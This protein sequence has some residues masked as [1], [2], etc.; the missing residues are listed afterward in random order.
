M[1]EKVAIEPDDHAAK[2]V[3]WTAAGQQFFL[4]TPFQPAVEGSRGGEYLA[5]YLFDADGR[6]SEHRIVDLGARE[7][8]D[9]A[10]A[11]AQ[12]QAMFE[13]L[14]PVEYRRIAVFPFAVDHDGVEFGLVLREPED[15]EDDAAVE[16]QPGNYMAFFEPWDS[17][18]YDT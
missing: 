14:G 8:L 12:L 7:T 5:L 10:A 1:A 16:A 2:Y 17:G 4:T 6:L 3:G 13:S 9:P 11:Q 18:E 15:E